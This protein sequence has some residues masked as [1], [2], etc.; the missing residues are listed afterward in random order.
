MHL[1]LDLRL[2]D[3]GDESH[4]SLV[5]ARKV[6][7]CTRDLNPFAYV[8]HLDGKEIKDSTNALQVQ[9]WRDDSTRALEI[10]GEYAGGAEKLAVENLER[11]PLSFILP[12]INRVAVSRCV[13]VGHLW[14]DGH[15]P[16]SYLQEALPRTK[17]IH[18]HGIAERDHES[19]AHTPPEKLKAVIGL[20]KHEN[21]SG[22][23]TLEVFGEEDFLSSM[24]TLKGLS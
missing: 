22:V 1:P 12:V 3:G 11:Y 18:I 4:L 16:L 7:N 6:I 5:K 13:D 8:L 9:Q 2:G 17:V 14:L 15:D 19:L 21:F 24:E 23:M 20:L 10:I